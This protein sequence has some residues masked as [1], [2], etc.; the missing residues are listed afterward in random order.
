M[1]HIIKPLRAVG[2]DVDVF[3]HTWHITGNQRVQ[4]VEFDTA[5]KLDELH[6][7]NPIDWRI[8]NQEEFERLINIWTVA[9]RL[10]TPTAR[11]CHVEDYWNGSAALLQN[12]ICSLESQKRGLA[13]VNTTQFDFIMFLRPDVFIDRPFPV[14]DLTFLRLHANG[15]LLPAFT[16]HSHGYNDQFAV[17]HASHA[18]AYGMRGDALEEYHRE[19]GFIIAEKFTRT[20]IN[21]N[22]IA[23]KIDICFW[24]VRPGGTKK[25]AE[26]CVGERGPELRT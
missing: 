26:L 9:K 7:L 13:M 10:S 2:I 1:R 8:D 16:T 14:G 6:L 17:V 18:A 3:L 5:Q 12:Y 20:V 25:G 22:Y 15:L 4:K 11:A 24:R 19:H 23:K 21:R